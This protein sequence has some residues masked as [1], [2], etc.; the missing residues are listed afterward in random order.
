MLPRGQYRFVEAEMVRA[1]TDSIEYRQ[2]FA[3]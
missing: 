3:Q 1:F 2:R